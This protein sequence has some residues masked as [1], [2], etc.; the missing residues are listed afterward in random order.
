MPSEWSMFEAA[1]HVEIPPELH[2]EASLLTYLGLSPAELKKVWYRRERMY[3]DFDVA[4]K[5][6]KFRQI[7]APD[8]RLKYL[9]RQIAV[10]LNSLYQRRNPV[11]GYVADRSVKT[12]ALSHLKQR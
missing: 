3:T 6:G 10:K 1:I 11:H 5:S 12:N 8:R 2:N 9:Q 4:K 7:N